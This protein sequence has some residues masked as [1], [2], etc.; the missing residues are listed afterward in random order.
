MINRLCVPERLSLSTLRL[1]CRWLLI[2]SYEQ[3]ALVE[4]CTSCSDIKHRY[5]IH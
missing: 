2:Y 4:V 1:N 5:N 3:L